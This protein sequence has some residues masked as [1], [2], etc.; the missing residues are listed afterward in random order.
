MTDAQEKPPNSRRGTSGAASRRS[1]WTTRTGSRPSSPSRQLDKILSGN[2]LDDYGHYRH[3]PHDEEAVADE[4]SSSDADLEEKDAEED[5]TPTS[6]GEVY[7]NRDGIEDIRD[8]EF[9][10]KLQ[11]TKSRKSMKSTK[12]RDPNLVTWDGPDDVE[13]PKNW[14]FS[15][16]WAATIIGIFYT[17]LT[18]EWSLTCS[19]IFIHIHLTSFIVNGCTSSHLYR[20][21]VQHHQ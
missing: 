21:R 6:S 3:H 8:V 17:S 20:F 1:S 13:N 19:S 14:A 7:E 12:S 4:E 18:I 5:I 15:R 9:G 16:K 11:K 10:P 2:H